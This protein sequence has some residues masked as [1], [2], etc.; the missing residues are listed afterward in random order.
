MMPV[1]DCVCSVPQALKRCFQVNKLKLEDDGKTI[2]DNESRYGD[3][4]KDDSRN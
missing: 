2:D 3:R 1:P 4:N